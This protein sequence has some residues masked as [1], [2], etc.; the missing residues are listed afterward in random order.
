MA[1]FNVPIFDFTSGVLT[2]KLKDQPNLEI[3]QNGVLIGEN[4][5]TSLHGPTSFRPG[6]VY[7]RPTR[8]NKSAWFV[9]FAFDDNEA[10]ALEFTDGYLRFH[11]NKGVIVESSQAIEGITQANPGVVTISSHGYSTG[12]E[13]YIDDVYGTTELN[14]QFFLLDVLDADTFSLT[15][16]DGNDIDTSSFETYA[17]GGTVEK[18]YE[19]ESPYKESEDLSL[20][21]TSQK[22][23]VMY[24]DHPHY[25][26]RK[27]IRSGITDWSLGTYERTDDPFDQQD[28]TGITQADPGVVTTDGDHYLDT[29][30][31]VIMEEIGGM[32]EVNGI[33]YTITVIS[34]TTFSIQDEDGNDIDTTGFGAYTSGGLYLRGGDAPATCGFYGSRLFH[35]GSRNDPDILFGSRSPDPTT[36]APR[37][38]DF[39][40]GTDADHAVFFAVT[41]ASDTSVDRI[42]FFIGTRQFLGVGT[43][44]GMLKVNGGSDAT[45]ISGTQIESYPIDSYGVANSM[46]VSF[47][48]DILYIERGRRVVNS[49]KYTIMNDGYESMDENVHS[50]EITESGIKQLVYTQGAPNRIWAVMEDGTILSLVYNRNENR[51]AWNNH[52][53]AGGGKVLSVASEPQDNR[54]SRLWACIEREIDGVTRRYVEYLE[55]NEMIPERH[56][57]YSGPEETD[58]DTDDSRYINML[59][60]AQKRQ[61][62]L[63]SALTLDTTQDTSLTLAD[64]EGEDIEFTAGDHVFTEDDVGRKIHAKF[65][66][67]DESGVAIITAY[68]STQVVECN[69]LKEFSSTTFASG[70]WY[71]A[72]STIRG[73]SHLE[74]ETVRVVADGG[75]AGED[76]EVED[77]EIT[78]PYTCTYAIVG[79]PYVGRL[80]SM[81]IELLIQSGITPGKTKTISG[82]HLMFRNSLGVSYGYDPYNLQKIG[83]RKGAQYTD[84]PTRLFNGVKTVPGFD[85][86]DAQRHIWVIQTAP[87]P[88]TLNAMVVDTEVDFEGGES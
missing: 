68:T 64:T 30:D 23:D 45:P 72:Q 17:G 4:W 34:G 51:S 88:C 36:G 63:D 40:L 25:A 55:Y 74:G 73:L 41:S 56:E 1:E 87:Y 15:D 27:L 80:K 28:I 58:K 47:G 65:I 71:F 3:Y 22:A 31:T 2:L 66:T 54:I 19:I 53:I 24:I 14:G 33:E 38:D 50:D 12:D 46:P 29:G 82:V 69:I 59:F 18:V 11:S 79:L 39:T 62:F 57:F 26:P 21:K 85:I 44:A 16:Q 35:G 37:F 43:Y 13:V 8:R 52:T 32:A 61:V 48:N 81:P 83:F 78:L 20:L 60:E 7:T 6:F 9:T 84:R 77:G 49:F 10:Y 70:G 86:W 75:V 76:Y 42:R 67:G 5:L